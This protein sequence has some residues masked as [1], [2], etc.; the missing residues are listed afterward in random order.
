MR[1][2]VD[3]GAPAADCGAWAGCEGSE[4]QHWLV[5]TKHLQ[6]KW[7]TNVGLRWNISVLQRQCNV[8]AELLSTG[9]PRHFPHYCGI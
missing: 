1:H 6:S 7:Q 5:E 3:L 2:V 4:R 9:V 8:L